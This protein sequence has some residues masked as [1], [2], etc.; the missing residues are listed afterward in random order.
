MVKEEKSAGA[1]IY[2]SEGKTIKFL[3][4]KYSNYW[5]FAK[6]KI[7]KGESIE[8][9]IKREVKEETNLEIGIIKGFKH[10]QKWFYRLNNQLINKEAVFL[11]AKITKEE[12]K[13]TKISP[14]HEEFKWLT[15]VEA[16]ELIKIKDNKDML[17][18][19]DEFIL[20]FEKI[21]N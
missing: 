14:E 5:G 11:L 16:Q 12:T 18:L 3:L 15:Y 8:E 9:T 10:I 21:K 4:L 2:Y 7:E 1:V 17:K 13:N 19:A 20:D 6:G